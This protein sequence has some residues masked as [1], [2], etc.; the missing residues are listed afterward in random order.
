MA[1]QHRIQVLLVSAHIPVMKDPLPIIRHNNSSYHKPRDGVLEISRIL[2]IEHGV[3][4]L[5]LA[6]LLR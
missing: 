1:P 2:E 6:C 5:F 3:A 4:F